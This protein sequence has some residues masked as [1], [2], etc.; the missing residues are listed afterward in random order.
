M[1]FDKI[2]LFAE[3]FIIIIVIFG[4]IYFPFRVKE[5]LVKIN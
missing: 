1:N 3:K 5:N 4:F 2:T